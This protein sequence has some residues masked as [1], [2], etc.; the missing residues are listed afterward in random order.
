MVENMKILMLVNWKV[1]YLEKDDSS[2]QPPDKVVEGGKYWF[3]KHW[4]ENNVDIHVIDYSRLRFLHTIEKNILKF[5]VY[6]SMRALLSGTSGFDLIISHGAQ[7]AVFFAFLRSSAGIRYPPHIVIDPASFNGGRDNLIEIL[8]IKFCARSISG[9]IY[10]S[11][12]QFEYYK[13]HLPFLVEKTKFIPF[14]VDIDFFTP[15]NLSV[16]PIILSFGER[17]RDYKTL[18]LAWSQ[19]NMKKI[20]LDIVGV[21]STKALGMHSLPNNVKLYGKVPIDVLKTMIAKAMF[22][23]IPLP[24]YNYSYG[25]MSVL[26]SMSMGKLV[27]TTK[28]PGTIDYVCDGNDAIF[29]KPYDLH[30]MKDKINMCI[31]NPELVTQIERNAREKV[32]RHFSEIAMAQDIFQFVKQLL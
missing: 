2:I 23:I 30:D 29:V 28:T 18:L 21:Q 24:Y 15:M 11:T 8:P 16:E 26:Q 22:I 14:G 19:L 13:K 4:Q 1:H 5:Y 20:R 6:Q 31:K 9:I 17:K 12:I 7:S 3:F 32:V 25:Q 27:I 10:H